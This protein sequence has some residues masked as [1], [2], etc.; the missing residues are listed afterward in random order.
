MRKHRWILAILLV[1][2]ASV[3]QAQKRPETH[4]CHLH[5]L[6][7]GQSIGDTINIYG[8]YNTATFLY[9]NDHEFY[10]T[11]GETLRFVYTAVTLPDLE[12]QIQA[13]SGS[14]VLVYAYGRQSATIDFPV[15]A[16]GYYE[17]FVSTQTELATGTYTLLLT[18]APAGPPAPSCTPSSGAVCLN[19]RFRV[20]ATFQNNGSVTT[21]VP[22][23]MTSDTAYFWFFS[24]NNVEAVVKVVDGRPLNGRFWVFAGGLTNVDCTISILDTQTGILR[25]YHNPANTAF[26]PIQ[27]TSAF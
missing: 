20:S 21:A 3:S 2:L 5:D 6:P 14:S 27:D 8:C 16:S 1:A 7:R 9:Y 24:S 17:C 23:V 19:T 15:T 18:T 13:R 22:V 10:A 25:T 26:Q 4:E 11:A 12:I